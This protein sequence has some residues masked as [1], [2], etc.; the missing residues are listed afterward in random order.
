ML[1][2]KK[3]RILRKISFMLSRKKKSRFWKR[4][5]DLRTMRP[6]KESRDSVYYSG[7]W[8]LGDYQRISLLA[9]MQYGYEISLL[10]EIK[11]NHTHTIWFLFC[12]HK[13]LKAELKSWLDQNW[14]KNLWL[15]QTSGNQK[16]SL[17]LFL[18]SVLYPDPRN[19]LQTNLATE[20]QI[21]F[22]QWSRWT[23]NQK[24]I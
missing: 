11:K 10:R 8:L 3:M 4:S 12:K 13:K 24:E 22:M 2:Y 14:K 17:S 20:A 6:Q 21:I 19:W 18:S 9:L 16:T 23:Q 7:H 5:S 1:V 15:S